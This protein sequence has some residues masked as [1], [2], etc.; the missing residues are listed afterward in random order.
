MVI[1]FVFIA[2]ISFLI[3]YVLGKRAGRSHGYQEGAAE[4]P[5]M[6][7]EQSLIQGRCCLCQTS[8]TPANRT[9]LENDCTLK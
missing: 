3:G 9:R 8:V 4:A 7:R 6:L 2:A 1:E 5:L